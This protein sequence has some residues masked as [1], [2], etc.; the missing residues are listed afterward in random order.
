MSE[1]AI[2]PQ[3]EE[4]D[5]LRRIASTSDGALFHRYLRRVLETVIDLQ[6]DGALREQNGRRSLARDLMRHMAEGLNEHGST[7]IDAPILSRPGKPAAVSGRARRDPSRFPRIDSFGDALNP[8]GSEP[9][10]SA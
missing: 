9:A 1:E 5:A 2:S 6:L 8:D 7:S 4:T 3:Q 10:K